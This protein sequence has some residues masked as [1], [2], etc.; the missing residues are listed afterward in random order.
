[1]KK[2][3]LFIACTFTVITAGELSKRDSLT[4]SGSTFISA[5]NE[6]CKLTDFYSVWLT[7]S[8]ESQFYLEAVRDTLHEWFFGTYKGGINEILYEESYHEESYYHPEVI[9]SKCFLMRT[10]LFKCARRFLSDSTAT[11]N[12]FQILSGIPVYLEQH[13]PDSLPF[14]KVNGTFVR[15][16]NDHLIPQ[17]GEKILGYTYGELYKIAFARLFRVFTYGYIVLSREYNVSSE[18][19]KYKK[20]VAS[21]IVS[22]AD[23]L[24]ECYAR[25]TPDEGYVYSFGVS[26]AI[27]FWLRRT[28]DGSAKELWTGLQKILQLYDAKWLKA[29]MLRTQ[30]D[31]DTVNFSVLGMKERSKELFYS[32]EISTDR[33]PLDMNGFLDT[34]KIRLCGRYPLDK[35]VLIIDFKS[36]KTIKSKTVEYLFDN[37]H[38]QCIATAIAPSVPG[39]GTVV[40]YGEYPDVKFLPDNCVKN[41]RIID[42]LNGQCL[43]DGAFDKSVGCSDDWWGSESSGRCSLN[44]NTIQS[45][46]DDSLQFYL[47]TYQLQKHSRKKEVGPY[48]VIV[49][50][51]KSYTILQKLTPV[52]LGMYCI[53]KK[54]Y[55]HGWEYECSTGG[56]GYEVF[57]ISKDSVV[58]VGHRSDFSD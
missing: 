43:L 58:L 20:T 18:I 32:T 22:G 24:T 21:D 31:A 14:R 23:Y 36:R 48:C 12:P 37:N 46:A 4:D 52:L 27:G 13:S 42:S 57:E 49:S 19:S 45:I 25:H 50:N 9:A 34:C 38:G 33:F 39:K 7:D 53:N 17:P 26:N 35:E 47:L 1:M 5:T 8:I 6:Y 16:A 30:R 10:G 51:G 55:I 11:V 54:A 28:M 40:I 56:S 44:V 41:P 3:I 2:F 15:W 29:T